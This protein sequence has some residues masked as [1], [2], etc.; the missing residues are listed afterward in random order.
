[1]P[2]PPALAVASPRSQ[3]T[4]AAL[5]RATSTAATALHAAGVRAGDRVGL[6]M[7][8]SPALVVA[9]LALARL[10]CSIVLLDERG[11]GSLAE[12]VALTGATRLV[13]SR[14]TCATEAADRAGCPTIDGDGL[15]ALAHGLVDDVAD[16]TL[17]LEELGSWP[18]A[19]RPDGLTLVTS[20]STGRPDVVPRRPRDFI[21]N[22]RRTH[23]VI[24]YRPDDVLAPLLPLTHQYGLSILLL[25]IVLR[26]TVVVGPHDR[27]LEALRLARRFRATVVDATPQAHDAVLRAVE[28]GRIE[29]AGLDSVRHWCVGGGPVAASLQQRAQRVHGSLLLDGY[30]STEL[31]NVAHVRPDDPARLRALPGIRLCVVAPDGDELPPGAWGHL[32]VLTPDAGAGTWHP[33]GDLASLETDGTLVVRGRHEAVLRNGLVVYPAAVERAAA[34]AGILGACVTTTHPATAQDRLVLVV[35]DR[36]RHG[37]GYWQRRVRDAVPPS[38]RPDRVVVRDHLPRTPVTHK[39]DRRRIRDFVAVL[40]GGVRDE[41]FTSVPF[42][43][44]IEALHRVREHLTARSDEVVQLLLPYSSR[45]AAHIELDATLSALAGAE[46]EVV[47]HR[48]PVV[49]TSWVHMPSNVL[50]YSYA[51]YVLIPALFTERLVLRPSSR[52]HEATVALHR[53]LQAVHGLPVT[54]VAGTQAE[55]VRSRGSAPGTIVFTGRY[56]N[57]EEVRRTLAPGQ[58]MLFFGQGTNPI[59]VGEG[60]DAAAAAR[61]AV[62]MRLLNSGQ[63][64][65]GPDLHLVHRAV[66]DEFVLTVTDLL[67]T[68]TLESIVTAG[69]DH[70]PIADPLVLRD[71]IEHVGRHRAHVRWGGRVDLRRMLVEPTVLVWDVVDAPEC[72]EVFAPVLNIAVYD[73]EHQVREVLGSEFYRERSMCASLYGASDALAA[74]C[75]DRMTTSVDASIV[76]TDDP[77]QAFG[78]VGG[79]ANY[80]A[81][82]GR[83]EIGP[84]L[85][86]EAVSRWFSAELP[87]PTPLAPQPLRRS[88][89]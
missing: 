51:L 61:D 45:E 77:N 42:P 89:P 40:D 74:W 44:R 43:M 62:R 82:A 30:G 46:A 7:P 14:E 17:R 16:D 21:A 27:V 37:P 49:P 65:F 6:C 48:P 47:M 88:T 20:G 33:T 76:A 53:A 84:L 68:H 11:F 60:A 79:M 66:A 67:A 15:A 31:G 2:H 12:A 50:L 5:A 25:G 52:V 54:L 18:W 78:G 28:T 34:E 57:A 35:E 86:S 55:L 69:S 22:L 29:A 10:D 26:L 83:T 8:N 81:W 85:I 58:L 87:E 3:L 23:D 32:L 56:P 9:F 4:H 64:C 38:V 13:L 63:D 80:A 73:D 36:L 71:V 59:L 24:G 39:I 1:M 19:D 70:V 41:Q 72:S 75:S